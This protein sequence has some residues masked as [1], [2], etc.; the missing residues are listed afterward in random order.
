[1]RIATTIAAALLGVLAPSV[2]RAEGAFDVSLPVDAS[3]TAAAW[4]GFIGLNMGVAKRRPPPRCSTEACGPLGDGARPFNS[5]WHILSYVPVSLAVSGALAAPMA[6]WAGGDATVGDAGGS[7]LM[8]AQAV[9]LNVLATE[10]VKIAV[11][12]YRPFLAFPAAPGDPGHTGRDTTA[13][14]WSG[15]TSV[16]FASAAIGAFDACRA[17]NPLGCAG[18]A[19][20]L[21]VLAATAGLMRVLAGKHH[22][23]DVIAGAITGGAIG[24]AVALLHGKKRAGDADA[25]RTV[26]GGQAVMMSML[27]LW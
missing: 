17:D 8:L 3:I 16:A 5:T 26:M 21:H 14:F 18:P 13:S 9:G 19:I 12:R 20:G 4:A 10:V 1:M 2:A 24:S 27:L 6:R 25:G 22:V 23:S 7:T 11:P 15:H